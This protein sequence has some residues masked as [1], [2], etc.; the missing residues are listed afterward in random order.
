MSN[1]IRPGDFYFTHK[2]KNKSETLTH[3]LAEG[4][5]LWL[6]SQRYG[7]TLKRIQKLNRLKADESIKPGEVVWLGTKKPAT[8]PR[9]ETVEVAVAQSEE[10]EFFDWE[11]KPGTSETVAGKKPIL[12]AIDKELT[13]QTISNNDREIVNTIAK[14]G[15]HVVSQGETLY[16]I[17]KKYSVGV[18]Q[19]LE[20]NQLDITQGLKPGQEISIISP[21]STGMQA[22]PKLP[23]DKGGAWVMHE[24]KTSDTLYSVA[25]QYNVTIKEIMDWNQ[26]S[27]FSL[28]QGEKLKILTK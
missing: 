2:K 3:T 8:I 11:V 22:E 27:D 6:V 14:S 15:T 9:E 12:V 23:A 17:S 4:E 1:S 7:V 18:T 20:W 26:K 5:D 19:L 13:N 21:E 24:V 28:S 16:S 10:G 25:R